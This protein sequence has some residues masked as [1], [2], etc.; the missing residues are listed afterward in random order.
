MT[1]HS[2]DILLKNGHVIDPKNSID[3]KMDVAIEGD[4][5][6]A[7]EADMNPALASQVVDVSGLYITPG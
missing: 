7:V 6:A 1:T 3:S 4:R 5:I 2:Y